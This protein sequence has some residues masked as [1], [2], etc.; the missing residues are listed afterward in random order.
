MKTWQWAGIVVLMGIGGIVLW[1]V[2]RRKPQLKEP[3]VTF[4]EPAQK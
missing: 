4:A 1:Y 3:D 2:L